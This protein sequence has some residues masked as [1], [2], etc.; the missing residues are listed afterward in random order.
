MVEFGR[1]LLKFSGPNRLLFRSTWSQL[2]RNLSTWLLNISSNGDSTTSPGEPVP[3]LSHPVWWKFPD[4]HRET[5][6]L[7]FILWLCLWPWH[8]APLKR[9]GSVTFAPSLQ[10]MD[11][12]S[13]RLP[14]PQPHLAVFPAGRD[15]SVPNGLG[16]RLKGKDYLPHFWQHFS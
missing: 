9:P 8:W 10:Y 1:G 11:E 16:G 12:M 14:F 2:P 4:V 15:V 7:C 6:F 13:L 5:P 3:G